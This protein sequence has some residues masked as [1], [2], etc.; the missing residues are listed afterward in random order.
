MYLLYLLNGIISGIIGIIGG[1]F[2]GRFF[3]VGILGN[4]VVVGVD[5]EGWV[6]VEEIVVVE[7]FDCGVCVLFVKW[8][9]LL[10]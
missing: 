5:I 2:V 7:V 3:V 6:N 4:V 1:I 9:I 10:N 8:E